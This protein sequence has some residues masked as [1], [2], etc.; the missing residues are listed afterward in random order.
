MTQRIKTRPSFNK[1]AS[2]FGIFLVLCLSIVSTAWPNSFYSQHLE[3]PKAVYV[4]PSGSDDT[5]TL[6]Q[7]INRVQSATGQGIV[8]LAPGNYCLTNTLYV[9]PGIRVIGYGVDRPVITLPANTPG[10]GNASHEKYIIFFAG[11]RP[12]NA[13]TD[14]ASIP[15]ANPGTFYSALANID[16]QVNDGNSGAVA[17]RARYAQHCFLA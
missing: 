14:P 8:L 5:V 7:A 6:Q 12:A 10:F 16:V 9:W 13:D 11:H 2:A 4:T 15:D 3:D 1:N 17:V